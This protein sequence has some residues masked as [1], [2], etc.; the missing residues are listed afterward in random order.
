MGK[1][2]GKRILARPRRRWQD[3]I[4]IDLIEI[5]WEHGLV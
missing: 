5:E 3:D 1:I 4:R 2:E